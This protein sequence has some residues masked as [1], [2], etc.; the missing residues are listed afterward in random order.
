MSGE[1]TSRVY[2]EGHFGKK[3]APAKNES[4]PLENVVDRFGNRKLEMKF[5]M[6]CD[7]GVSTAWLSRWG[8]DSG[9]RAVDMAFPGLEVK[10]LEL[11]KP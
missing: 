4:A 11:E 7:R 8:L 2:H 9:F 6:A 5:G 1:T 10:K 3:Y